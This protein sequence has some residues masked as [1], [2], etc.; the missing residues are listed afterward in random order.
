MNDRRLAMLLGATLRLA[1]AGQ[2]AELP[3]AGV[4]ELRGLPANQVVYAFKSPYVKDAEVRMIVQTPTKM[5]AGRRYPVLYILNEYPG[6]CEG[7]REAERLKIFDVHAVICVNVGT[8]TMPW[9]ADHPTNASLR[10]ESFLLKAAIPLVDE[11]HP[12]IREGGGRFLIGYSKGGFGAFTLLL[13]HPDL[14]AKAA[15]WDAPLSLEK[16]DR[17]D[18]ATVYGTQENYDRYAPFKLFRQQ[19]KQFQPGPPRFVLLGHGLFGEE[20]RKTH[21]LLTELGIPHDYDNAV[22]REHNWTSGWFGD[23]V[24]RLLK[25][26]PFVDQNATCGA[27]L[28][29]VSDSK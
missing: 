8:P 5:E 10:L 14:F 2:E 12:T 4:R 3:Y 28:A 22:K 21:D 26:R 25:G 18:M 19:A 1:A 7:Y 29:A 13:R 11:K 17:W 15:A 27:V 16:P 9:Y 24:A 6:N 20:T 23:A